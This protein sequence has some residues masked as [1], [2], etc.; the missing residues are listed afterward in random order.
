MTNFAVTNSYNYGGYDYE[1]IDSLLGGSSSVSTGLEG[2]AI[3]MIIAAILAII[4]GILVYFLFVKA[5]TEP[6]GKF[7][8][9]LKDFLSFKIMWI[10]PIL[11]VVYYIATIFVILFSFSFLALGGVGVLSF[12]MC[13][14]FGPIIVR[15]TY[16][17][18]MMFIMIWRN[19]RDIVA[20][21]EKKK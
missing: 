16:E 21:T 9:W 14:I 5:K 2:A 20:N 1:N 7:A 4:G 12:F 8:K 6:K 3:W 13:L 11:K 17:M 19:T 15:L 18:T 10:E